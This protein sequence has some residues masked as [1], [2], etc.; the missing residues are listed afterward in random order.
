MRDAL[1]SRQIVLEGDKFIF[2]R[3]DRYFPPPV[4]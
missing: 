2:S 1:M 3:L 4:M